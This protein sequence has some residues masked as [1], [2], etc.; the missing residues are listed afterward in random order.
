MKTTVFALAA[1]VAIILD[2]AAAQSTVGLGD[3]E[4][5]ASVFKKCAA[6]HKVGPDAKSGMG[7]VLNGIVGRPAGTYPGYKYSTANKNS[8]LVWDQPTLTEYLRSPSALVPNT[9]MKFPGLKDDKDIQDVIAFL[10]QFDA[11]GHSTVEK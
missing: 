6:C 4:A 1:A 11:D 5:G 10:K 9:T 7:P 3:A 2:G 8:G